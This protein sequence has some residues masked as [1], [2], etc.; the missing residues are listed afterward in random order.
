MK[1]NEELAR[2]LKGLK[3]VFRFEVRNL[4]VPGNIKCVKCGSCRFETDFLFAHGESRGEVRERIEDGEIGICGSCYADLLAEHG[5]AV[6]HP[7]K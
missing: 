5:F 4:D 3:T 7:N 2:R 1:K 6:W